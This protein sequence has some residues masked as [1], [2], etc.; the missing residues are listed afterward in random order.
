MGVWSSK[1]VAR[2]CPE[3]SIVAKSAEGKKS[4]ALRQLNAESYY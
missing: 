3:P 4:A 1:V 2:F